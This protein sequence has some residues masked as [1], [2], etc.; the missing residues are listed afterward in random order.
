M[1]PYK[2]GI[3]GCGGRGGAHA[4]GYAAS[5]DAELVAF[6]DPVTEK[7]EALAQK[8]NV[9]NVYSDYK[10]MLDKEDLDIVSVCTWTILHTEMI[11]AAASSGVRAIHAEKPMAPTWGEAKTQYQTCMDNN[12]QLTF[13]HQLRFTAACVKA[14]QVANDGTIGQLH[15]LEGYCGNMIDMGTH[16]L[17]MMFFFNNEEP[18]EWVMGQIHCDQ[19]G[20]VFGVPIEN[21]GL[22][23]FKWKN[24]VYGLLVTGGDIGGR[25][26]H[27]LIGSDGIIE[28]GAPDAPPVRVMSKESAGW[29]EADL[30]GVVP[31]GGDTTLGVF[32]L[33]ECLKTGCEPVLSG[34]KALQAT[35][36]IFATYES[37]RRRE[38]IYLPLAIE[39]SPLISMIKSGMIGSKRQQ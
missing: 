31:P 15:R 35:E 38:R 18:A 8:H 9:T 16:R 3:I 24:G 6:A 1:A 32:D 19:E 30:N 11:V 36:L 5:E 14:K 7:A 21:H 39:D 23:Y 4:A 33:I 25:S 12:V 20:S 28:L 26:W 2:V 10:E 13:C 29:Q 17:D 27:R 37:S 22:S 34:R